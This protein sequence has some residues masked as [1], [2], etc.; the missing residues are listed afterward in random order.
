MKP[1]ELKSVYF[2]GIGGIGMSSIA[3]Y[4]HQKGI[5][6]SGYDR[7]PSRLTEELMAE[8]IEIHFEERP[9]CI[10]SEIELVIYTPAIPADNLEFRYAAEKGIPMMKRSQVLGLLTCEK[11]T[12]AVAGTHGK[13]TISTMAAHILFNSHLGCTAFLGGISKNH[14]SNFITKNGSNWVV[15]EADEYDH[16]FLELKPQIAIITAIDPDHL[17]IYHDYQNLVNAFKDFAGLISA[18]GLLIL[19]KGLENL[20]SGSY[21]CRK[22]TYSFNDTS[23][24]YFARDI[25]LEKMK[26]SY[27]IQTPEGIIG[28]VQLKVP[29]YV[30][31]ENSIAAFAAALAAGCS[32]EEIIR[33]LS[34]FE[35]IRRR[36]DI[37]YQS[38]NFTLIDDYAHHPEE[39]KALAISLR[40]LFPTKKLTAIFQPHLYS[41]TRDLAQGFAQSLSLFDEVFLMDIYPAREHPIH[42][43]DSQMIMKKMSQVAHLVTREEAFREIISRKHQVLATIGAGDIEKLALLAKE[44]L[45]RQKS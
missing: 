8:G 19:K 23:A 42:G 38:D 35:G 17:D 24:D 3:R 18:N 26:Y 21:L 29:A 10:P 43:V 30:N 27:S 34:D 39:I 5:S 25:L 40:N 14:Q 37:L 44:N 7:C 31:I 36:F 2:L 11:P 9:A 32:A 15:I 4:F 6:V 12:L 20:L 1:D 28:P 45:N 41:R 16:S 33:A 13:T 22:A